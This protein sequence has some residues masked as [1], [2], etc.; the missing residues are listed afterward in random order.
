MTFDVSG[1]L[2][3]DSA[4]VDVFLT[5]D[6]QI[7]VVRTD[8]KEAESAEKRRAREQGGDIL[9]S[10]SGAPTLAGVSLLSLLVAA[11]GGGGGGN[12]GGGGG[13]SSGIVIDG[14]LKGMKVYRANAPETFVVSDENGNWNIG[15]T[16]SFVSA[17]SAG[18]AVDSSTGVSFLGT[19]TAPEGA[20]VISPI[21][22]IIQKMG[23]V[24]DVAA[25]KQALGISSSVNPLN[26]N[27]LQSHDVGYQLVSAQVANI[28][29]AGVKNSSVDVAANLANA[30]K[31]APSTVDLTS[32]TFIKSLGISDSVAT[33]VAK[34]NSVTATDLDGIAK[35]Q[36]LVQTMSLADATNLQAAL[37]KFTTDFGTTANTVDTAAPDASTNISFHAVGGNVVDGALNAT[38]TNLVATATIKAGQATNGRAEL[39]VGNVKIASDVSISASDTTVNFD[40]GTT[41]AAALQAAVANGG[42]VSIKIYDVA[43]NVVTTTVGTLKADYVAPVVQGAAVGGSDQAIST[44]A[45]D[46]II[47]G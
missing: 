25:L 14:Y 24:A 16:G 26:Y 34:A 32:S 1:K 15:G 31:N 9:I 17:P 20:T 35:I 29:A 11:C 8:G 23:A 4:G 45:G 33:Q 41:S 39:Y 21:T 10:R 18:G 28:L 22:T 27:P 2:P 13:G 36:K 3:S 38:N 5:A 6:G 37:D 7:S 40:L 46:N 30:I 43:G 42:V 47:S 19:L 44:Q 12:S